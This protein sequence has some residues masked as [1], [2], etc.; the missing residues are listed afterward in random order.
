MSN[1]KPKKRVLVVEDND[2]LRE[3]ITRHFQYT[4]HL[5]YDFEVIEAGTARAVADLDLGYRGLD[6]AVV[7]LLLEGACYTGH[8]VT[9][10]THLGNGSLPVVIYTGH[11]TPEHAFKAGMDGARAIL[12]KASC[13]VQD[14]VE[15]VQQELDLVDQ[16]TAAQKE[17]QRLLHDHEEEWIKDYAKAAGHPWLAIAGGE[18]VAQGRNRLDL[19]LN[20]TSLRSKRADLPERPM[21][22]NLGL[23]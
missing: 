19:L 23:R 14:L 13:S 3:V 10:C 11:C 20:Y 8:L 2:Q 4:P 15:R 9:Y 7:D 18:V 21:V 6:A 22:V 12:S 5:R 1:D 17:L 16:M